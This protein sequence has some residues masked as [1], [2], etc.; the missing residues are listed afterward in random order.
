MLF[1]ILLISSMPC[2]AEEQLPL[3]DHPDKRDF[4]VN[5][6]KC[7]LS[8]D[9]CELHTQTVIDQAI[10]LANDYSTLLIPDVAQSIFQDAYFHV[11]PSSTL[12]MKFNHILGTLAFS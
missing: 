10:R 9:W 12:G 6:N 3:P 7:R 11:D 8:G 2:C 5:L 1:I 4:L